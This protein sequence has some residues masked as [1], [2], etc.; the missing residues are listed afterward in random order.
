MKNRIQQMI[1]GVLALACI[2]LA[3]ELRS[4]QYELKQI[5]KA[6]ADWFDTGDFM[7]S[8]HIAVTKQMQAKI[9]ALEHTNTLLTNK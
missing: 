3:L 2:A 6:N 5:Q 1:I 8:N 4:S 7:L 9:E